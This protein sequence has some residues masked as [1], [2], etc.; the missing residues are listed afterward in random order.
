M[1]S[2]EIREVIATETHVNVKNKRLSI[3][4]E[5]GR[6]VLT[7]S[8]KRP[9]AVHKRLSK[10]VGR[11]VAILFLTQR[12]NGETTCRIR[13]VEKTVHTIRAKNVDEKWI[14]LGKC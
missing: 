5:L 7:F 9:D 2:G 14:N 8:P 10:F 6:L 4:L 13:P 1:A 11:K 3:E 12:Q